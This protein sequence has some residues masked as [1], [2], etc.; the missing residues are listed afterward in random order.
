LLGLAAV[1]YRARSSGSARDG[2]RET[3]SSPETSS[4]G[5][6][7]T[8]IAV[9]PFDDLSPGGDHAWLANGMAEELIEM[10]SRT[11]AFQ[12]VARTST[13]V[14]KAKG[15]DIAAIGELLNVGSVVEGSVRSANDQLRVTV[16]LIRVADGYHLWS[17]RYD[18]KLD[19][20]FAIQEEIGRE[21]AEAL[22]AEL[23]VTDTH[24]WI[25]RARYQPPDVRAYEMLRKGVEL[26]SAF[27]DQ[28]SIRRAIDYFLEAIDIDP[29]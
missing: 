5:A 7:L 29:D 1:L 9:L 11:E 22:R 8:A 10:L 4:A 2:V 24:S 3:S 19:D 27:H 13:Q 21:V 18:R 6:P 23:G 20:V 26:Y 17:G 12:V 15:A 28:E 25:S 16:Q 14:A